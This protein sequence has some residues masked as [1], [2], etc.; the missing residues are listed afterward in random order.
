MRRRY[1]W[2]GIGLA[3]SV[4]MIIGISFFRQAYLQVRQAF[5]ALQLLTEVQT[6]LLAHHNAQATRLFA[7]AESLLR[8]P[9]HPLTFA[10]LQTTLTA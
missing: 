1:L 8:L 4:A 6:D 9:L 10:Q 7:N 5:F 3:A 2:V